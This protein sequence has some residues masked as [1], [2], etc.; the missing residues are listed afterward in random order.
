MA[1]VLAVT[2][3]AKPGHEAEVQDILRILGE[4]SR[5]EAGVITYTT[6]VT[7][8]PRISRST[9]SKGRSRCSN[10]GSAP[11]SSIF[12]R[13]GGDKAPGSIQ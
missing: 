10:P 9:C 1:H 5:Q 7:S 2:W 4:A 13:N 12:R 6:H 3:V 11:P 8:R